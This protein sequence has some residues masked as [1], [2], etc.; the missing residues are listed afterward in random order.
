MVESMVMDYQNA[1]AREEIDA[2]YRVIRERR[3]VRSGYSP[4]PLEDETM[5]RL[6]SAAHMAPSVG[7]MQPWRF[8]LVRDAAQRANVHE[9]FVRARAAAATLY[10]GDRRELH[11]R[12]K[13]E[14]LLEA[15]Q[16]LCV[17]CDANSEQGHALGRH[18]MPETAA[19]SVVCAIQNLW[20]AARAEGIAVG[21]VS[22]LDPIA[23]KTLFRIPSEVELVA[24]L[25][26]GY[27]EKFAFSPDL[28][29]IGWEERTSLQ[30]VLREEFF[31]FPAKMGEKYR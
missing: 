11:A 2:V 22:I 4:R 13:L 28:E 17:V 29:R 9:I 23:M 6:L 12:L 16:H 21:W 18:S 10:D 3:D 30:S 15:P 20:L 1:F 5:L 7:L 31:N 25:C 8:I 26:I 27:V 24:Y 19:Y 14:A